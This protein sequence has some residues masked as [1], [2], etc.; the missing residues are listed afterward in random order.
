MLWP[1]Q[2]DSRAQTHFRLSDGCEEAA[3]LLEDGDGQ[4]PGACLTGAEQH[5]GQTFHSMQDQTTGALTGGARLQQ[6]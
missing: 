5:K 6:L 4:L 2:P 3:D 1:L